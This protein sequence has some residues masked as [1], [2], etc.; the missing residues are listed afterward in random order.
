M[1]KRGDVITV[2]VV[3]DMSNSPSPNWFDAEQQLQQFL[4]QGTSQRQL[5]AML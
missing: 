1:D 3:V 2:L 5:M 4:E